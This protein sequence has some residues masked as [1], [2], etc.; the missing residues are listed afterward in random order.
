[1]TC[2]DEVLQSFEQRDPPL[3]TANGLVRDPSKILK[4]RSDVIFFVRL[5]EIAT[6]QIH[7][8]PGFRILSMQTLQVFETDSPL[9][10]IKY[11]SHI[12]KI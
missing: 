5:H 1:M 3:N 7:E 12:N 8:T 6:W 2:T 10:H 9:S 4:T 11:Q